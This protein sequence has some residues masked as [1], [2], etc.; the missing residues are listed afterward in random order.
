MKWNPS[1]AEL[2]A[3]RKVHAP[4]ASPEEF[5][6]W[7]E[8]CKL[9]SLLPVVDVVLQM[10]GSYEYDSEA[11][12]SLWKKKAIYI[13]TIHALR[14]LA[15]RTGLY[16]GPCPSEWIYLNNEHVPTLTSSVPL[17]DPKSP[18]EWLAP[19]AVR[20][21][22]KRKG[23]DNPVIA[24]ARWGAY[25]QMVKSGDAVKL[26][27]VWKSRGPEQLE[28]CAMAQAL[29]AAFPEELAGLYT[30][31]EVGE[32]TLKSAAMAL[33]VAPTGPA[34]VATLVP[35]KVSQEPAKETTQARPQ[36]KAE[37][38]QEQVKET[39]KETEMPKRRGWPKGKKRQSLAKSQIKIETVK[40]EVKEPAK[41]PAKEWDNPPEEITQ[42][43][44]SE[45][46]T[47]KEEVVKQTSKEAAK[48]EAKNNELP[49]PDLDARPDQAERNTIIDHLKGY[50][51]DMKALGVY[52]QK[53]TGLQVPS[54]EATRK[55]WAVVVE[56]L[57]NL[58]AQGK[59]V[60]ESAIKN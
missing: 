50:G 40:Q 3:L 44:E 18:T 58:Y 26:N 34:P 28:K 51:V 60:L 55:Q 54:K 48:E 45:Q 2:D 47:S 38:K 14:K 4:D 56:T 22:V 33:S 46:V 29:R 59:Q 21:S 13:T 7:V 36:E 32:D 20:A 24:V 27:S 1:P 30:E 12:A 25:A 16:L 8:G 52:I 57:D 6:L 31:E 43:V 42:P 53:L 5:L 19:W 35:E 23:F 9:R 11:K 10:R 41:E 15:E 49:Y 39:S 17:P 37:I